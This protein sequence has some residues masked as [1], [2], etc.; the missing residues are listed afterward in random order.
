MDNQPS[1][2]SSQFEDP[3]PGR[4]A[5][6]QDGKETRKGRRLKPSY[7]IKDKYRTLYKPFKCGVCSYSTAVRSNLKVHMLRHGDKPYKCDRCNYAAIRKKQFLAHVKHH[8][9]DSPLKC[10]QCGF[11]ANQLNVL[12]KHMAVH[13][14]KEAA[15]NDTVGASQNEE[16]NATSPTDGHLGNE[17]ET[18]KKSSPST[19]YQQVIT[20]YMSGRNKKE[21]ENATN[22]TPPVDEHNASKETI[23]KSE[24]E[25][26]QENK[27]KSRLRT[28]T[29]K[30]VRFTGAMEA[31]TEVSQA[32]GTDNGA[33]LLFL[34]D[35]VPRPRKKP[36]R[37]RCR[38]CGFSTAYKHTLTK[39]MLLHGGDR[40]YK[41]EQCSYA[42][43]RQAHLRVH[44]KC[45]PANSPL[46]CRQCGFSTR[47]RIILDRHIA[48]H[49]ETDAGTSDN[50]T[51]QEDGPSTSSAGE[52]QLFSD[53]CESQ[54]T[55]KPPARLRKTHARFRKKAS[56]DSTHNT[57]DK[58]LLQDHLLG[59][60]SSKHRK[61]NKW[62]KCKECS[63]SSPHKQTLK[64]HTLTHS[65]EKPHKCDQCSYATIRKSN[66][67]I[68]MKCH[69][70]NS[71]LTCQQC[72][73]N[74][75]HGNILGRHMAVH[76][77][78]KAD[79]SGATSAAQEVAYN[80][81]VAVEH[82]VSDLSASE[83]GN[84]PPPSKRRKTQTKSKVETP[85]NVT[86]VKSEAN[87]DDMENAEGKKSPQD[88]FLGTSNNSKQRSESKPFQ[89]KECG[90]S[91][92]Y[93]GDLKRHQLRHGGERPYK[94][95]KC[96]YAAIEKLTLLRHIERHTSDGPLKCVQCGFSAKS[97][98]VLARH[99]A[100]HR[101][102]KAG[103][104]NNL[105][106]ST[107]QDDGPSSPQVV[108]QVLIDPSESET[109]SNPPLARLRKTHAK[110]KFSNA[111]TT[112]KLEASKDG[113]EDTEGKQSPHVHRGKKT[114]K[115]DNLASSTAQDDGTSSP[116]VVNQQACSDPS[117]PET[118]SSPPPKRRKTH[119]RK[120]FS[121]AMNTLKLEASPNGTTENTED[122][123]SQQDHLLGT[124]NSIETSR[125]KPFQC[126]ECSYSTAYKA[127]LKRHQLRHGGERPY[128]CDQC[129][130]AAIEKLNLRRHMKRHTAKDPLKCV[131]CGF[132]TKRKGVLTRHMAV[133]RAEEAKKSVN[134]TSSSSTA[135]EGGHSPPQA[136]EQL[137]V[138]RS[139]S[140]TNNEPKRRK[141]HA[142]NKLSNVTTLK[143]EVH[144]NGTHDKKGQ[145][146]PQYH[147]FV[148][149][150]SKQRSGSKRFMCK[151]CGYA[152][153][154]TS[155]LKRHI[156]R[157]GVDKPHKCH[158]CPY[159]AMSKSKL[160]IHL[161]CH[162][163][164][165][166]L[167]CQQCGFSTKHKG[168]LTRHMA[169]HRAAEAKKRDDVTAYTNHRH[170]P[171]S[172]MAVRAKQKTDNDAT[173]SQEDIHS[174]AHGSNQTSQNR[175]RKYKSGKSWQKSTSS[176]YK[177]KVYKSSVMTEKAE[178]RRQEAMNYEIDT[179]EEPCRRTRHSL[180]KG[181]RRIKPSATNLSKPY[182]CGQCVYATNH[183]REFDQH[184]AQHSA[185]SPKRYLCGQCSFATSERSKWEMHMFKHSETKRFACEECDFKTNYEFTLSAH[186]QK[187][188]ELRKPQN[189]KHVSK[190]KLSPSKSQ[191]YKKATKVLPPKSPSYKLMYTV[192]FSKHSTLY[193]CKQCDYATA[194]KV[195][196]L[197]HV[198]TH[199]EEKP[200][201]GNSDSNASNSGKQASD[202]KASTRRLTVP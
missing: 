104:R 180:E 190:S 135:Q 136:E 84:E 61:G 179:G 109:D 196:M 123:Q 182:R 181:K 144:Q 76:R 39:H 150:N 97:R 193:N 86:T 118:N 169:V 187:V 146:S 65:G 78:E 142:R 148:N 137:V 73:F 96:P 74:T 199:T 6:T 43:I 126:K 129:S 131:Q 186:I 75:K 143:M 37:F 177:K 88:R 89:C 50:V 16:H 27:C 25:K 125:R 130:Y 200:Q 183:V 8:A 92:A 155:D 77:R 114:G 108:K 57:E 172:H 20:K 63:Y 41:C 191:S 9:A 95:D 55:S 132:S 31:R 22:A 13:T 152:T 36:K 49:T 11:S 149:S 79:K 141:M 134:V 18:S 60:L 85:N 34:D 26:T 176:K 10:K 32:D 48:G 103:K 124:S 160:L 21:D 19:S 99:M 64:R 156:V 192:D 46:K 138:D 158:K 17:L 168:V 164:D 198:K 51:T 153:D 102:K 5:G 67:L 175:K 106:S 62:F 70:T 4:V 111:M 72:G 1:A 195:S 12:T 112:A 157:H 69:A 53:L 40:P 188:H 147:L 100:L 127:D 87:Q 120:K 42:T 33:D 101:D 56:Q 93:K 30:R 189:D 90:Y 82:L 15:K 122:K 167:K 133:H 14:K 54:T 201:T 121:K 173:T 128:K 202:S 166:P 174:A 171:T 98:N 24:P 145:Q 163:A 105:T 59:T 178:E 28:R 94:C 110:K 81:A 68:H 29:K 113:T 2:E 151:E 140:Q 185:S 45:H 35:D 139:E 23:V 52:Q 161:K 58:Q 115:R 38:E 80:S 170:Q 194:L 162:T 66:L 165:G 71:P 3:T 119:A 117:E 116:Q 7:V 47:R 107:A 197:L 184:L 83:T 154:L 44:M 159:A 91:T